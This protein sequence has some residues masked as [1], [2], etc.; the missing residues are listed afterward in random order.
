MLHFHTN[1]PAGRPFLQASPIMS[2]AHKAFVC[3]TVQQGLGRAWPAISNIMEQTS[4]AACLTRRGLN[5]C[6]ICTE[7]LSKHQTKE[8]SLKPLV[9][10]HGGH[11]LCC[12][13]SSS[14]LGNITDDLL[15]PLETWSPIR[16]DA[17]LEIP[18][19][20]LWGLFCLQSWRQSPNGSWL[21]SMTLNQRSGG[22]LAR[23]SGPFSLPR[24]R[25][26]KALKWRFYPNL[27]KPDRV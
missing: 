4:R 3:D 22:G 14:G 21:D 15:N 13:C 16:S 23:G 6:G 18:F 5:R 7:G 11:K 25:A 27:I 1:I 10:M 9:K 19:V 20:L 2:C 24:R 26:K 12:I 17:Y 8:L